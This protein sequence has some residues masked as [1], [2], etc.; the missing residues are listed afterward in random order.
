M[1]GLDESSEWQ[2]FL[3]G[4]AA[5]TATFMHIPPYIKDQENSFSSGSST[6]SSCGSDSGGSCGSSCGG[7]GGCGGD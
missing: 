3:I 5:L 4:A 2:Y 1:T 7:C 6:S